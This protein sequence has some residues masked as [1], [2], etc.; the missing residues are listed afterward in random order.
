M[1]IDDGQTLGGPK[2]RGNRGCGLFRTGNAVGKR[3]GLADLESHRRL[4]GDNS[5]FFQ[6][7]EDYTERS[8]K[9]PGRKFNDRG[10]IEIGAGKSERRVNLLQKQRWPGRK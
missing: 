2:E 8:L 5:G 1:E 10:I 3:N 6:W 7:R 9:L 4:R